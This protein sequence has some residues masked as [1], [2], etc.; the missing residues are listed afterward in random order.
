M[1]LDDSL[2]RGRRLDEVEASLS[3]CFERAAAL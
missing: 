2:S 1:L 3:P